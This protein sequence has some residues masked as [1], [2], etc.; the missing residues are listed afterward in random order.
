MKLFGRPR[1]GKE[2][3]MGYDLEGRMQEICSC[4]TLCPCWT[5]L[6]PD[7][8]T[9]GFSHL[10]HF[11]RGQINGVEVAGL[12]IGV[13]GYLPGNFFDG[14]IRAKVLVDE[15]ATEAQEEQLLAAFTG[16]VGGPL[17]DLAGLVGEVVGVERVPMKFDVDQGSG[18]FRAGDQFEGEV[19]GYRS[20]NGAPTRLVDPAVGPV[21][22]SPAYPGKVVSYQV[23]DDEHGLEFTPGGAT[24]T[25]FHYITT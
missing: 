2:K 13:L 4:K 9:C 5:G 14:N 8:G 16:Q 6:D 19:E 17:A 7:G 1:N 21:L 11:D 22:G 20:L 15:R 12:N 3:V 18:R 10:F 25:E 24:Q 23:R